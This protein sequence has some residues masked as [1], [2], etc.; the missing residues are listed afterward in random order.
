MT[1]ARQARSLHAMYVTDSTAFSVLRGERDGQTESHGALRINRKRQTQRRDLEL[2][3]RLVR[4][5]RA[6]GPD[7][8]RGHELQ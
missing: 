6:R 3:R 5:E 4:G 1:G 8:C 2:D 7:G